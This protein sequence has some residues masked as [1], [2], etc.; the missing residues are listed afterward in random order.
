MISARARLRA[1]TLRLLGESLQA[2]PAEL[3]SLLGVVRSKLD[4]SLGGLLGPGP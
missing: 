4:V 1:E 3:E 2:S